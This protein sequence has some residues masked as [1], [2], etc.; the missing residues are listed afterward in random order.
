[1]G[2][3]AVN[4]PLIAAAATGVQVGAAIVASRYA[5]AE[6]PPFTLA[7]FRY[8]IGFACVAPFAWRDRHAM[9]A[10]TPV[11]GHRRDLAALAGSASGS[12]GS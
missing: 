3:G 9:R 10:S 5:V 11:H 12:S 7:M 6:V 2:I 1:V 4:V 8:G